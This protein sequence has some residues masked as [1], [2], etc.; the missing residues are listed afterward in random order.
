[1]TSA[2]AL[3]GAGLDAV[4]KFREW[5]ADSVPTAG[6]GLQLGPE[7][8]GRDGDLAAVAGLH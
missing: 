5:L 7:G 6:H 2:L 3:E 8:L 1:M 4:E